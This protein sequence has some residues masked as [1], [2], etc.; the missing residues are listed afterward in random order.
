MGGWGTA[1]WAGPVR[2]QRTEPFKALQKQRKS[3]CGIQSFRPLD[4][5]RAVPPLKSSAYCFNSAEWPLP[6]SSVDC[7]VI[8]NIFPS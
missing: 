6:S 1:R 8:L 2:V 7:R 5:D 4:A 3:G